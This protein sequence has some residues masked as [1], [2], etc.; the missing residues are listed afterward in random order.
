MRVLWRSRCVTHSLCSKAIVPLAMLREKLL[1]WAINFRTC[2]ETKNCNE[3][4]SIARLVNFNCVLMQL[5]APCNRALR[6]WI[7]L[8]YNLK[9]SEVNK[10]RKTQMC[11]VNVAQKD[12]KMCQIYFPEII[13][14]CVKYPRL[15]NKWYLQR[16]LLTHFEAIL[17]F[18]RCEFTY[19]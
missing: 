4:Q 8:L 16:S 2:W 18:R 9:S 19:P 7:S 3:L 13:S 12:F 15:Q 11:Q 17:D 6:V 14:V 10:V 5:I 1:V